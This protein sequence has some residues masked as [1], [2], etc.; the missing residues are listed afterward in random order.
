ML[1]TTH[2]LFLLPLCVLRTSI[3]GDSGVEAQ[4]PSIVV[5]VVLG[6]GVCEE[7][8][9]AAARAGGGG[10]AETLAFEQGEFLGGGRE[11]HVG[12]GDVFVLV[13]VLCF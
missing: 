6:H 2:R 4:R 5:V 10:F 9:G 13:P 8:F 12:G 1:C 7:G 11:E 3:L